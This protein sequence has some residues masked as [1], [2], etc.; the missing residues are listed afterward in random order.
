MLACVVCLLHFV[1]VCLI[2]TRR[3]KFT[4]SNRLVSSWGWEEWRVRQFWEYALPKVRGRGPVL[5]VGK[6]WICRRKNWGGGNHHGLCCVAFCDPTLANSLSLHPNS[7][8]AAAFLPTIKIC[9]LLLLHSLW[10]ICNSFSPFP[11][12]QLSTFVTVKP[13]LITAPS[14]TLVR[15]AAL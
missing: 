15:E 8:F 13:S 5:R 2:V 3:P 7:T 4:S 11:E 10:F 1:F 12:C 9:A 6:S 14:F